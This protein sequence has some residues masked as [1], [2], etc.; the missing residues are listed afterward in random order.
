[1]SGISPLL[2]L[3]LIA[4]DVRNDYSISHELLIDNRDNRE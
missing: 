1:M 2:T 3:A 4:F